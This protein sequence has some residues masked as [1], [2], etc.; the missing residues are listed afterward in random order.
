[1]VS[2]VGAVTVDRSAVEMVAPGQTVRLYQAGRAKKSW[3]GSTPGTGTSL[4]V[5][6]LGATD[7]RVVLGVPFAA[8]RSYTHTGTVVWRVTAL[9]HGRTRFEVVSGTASLPAGLKAGDWAL[10]GDGS[11][12]AGTT[13]PSVFSGANRGRFRVAA[14]NSSTYF[15][16]E[17]DGVSETVSTA[18]APFLFAPY[19]SAM[20]GDQVVLQS[21]NLSL[22]NRGTFVVKSVYSLYAVD[23]ANAAA[24]SE[25]PT[26]VGVLDSVYLADQGFSSFR[27]VSCVA[28]DPADP[29]SAA[30]LSFTPSEDAALFT[31]ARG[32]RV[33]FPNR[34]GYET[35]PVPG[36]SGYQYWTGLKRRVQRVVDG[37]EPDPET[38]PGVRAS[39]ASIEVR[40]PQIQR[41]EVGIR[42]KTKDGVALQSIADTVKSEIVGYVNSLG[43]GQDVILSEIVSLVQ[44]VDGVDSVVLESPKLDA[45]RV[46]VGDKSV[47]RTSPSEITLSSIGSV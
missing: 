9:G 27:T 22:A 6:D 11:S 2:S 29:G 20:P 7:A 25:G 40:E 41:V 13:L 35:K 19:H 12:Y 23:Y 34:L 1:V 21:T 8:L 45:E 30:V 37:W 16:V 42:V 14:T 15:D 47:A 32:A 10:T 33:A 28:P 36:A 17:S 26:T 39:G 43:L 44:A 24:L 18:T 46:A 5:Q 3:T 4:E 31:E 38:Y